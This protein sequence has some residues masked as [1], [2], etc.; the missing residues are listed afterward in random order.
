MP[1]VDEDAETHSLVE[2]SR[3]MT[4]ISNSEVRQELKEACKHRQSPCVADDQENSVAP[5]H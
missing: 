2:E 4:E 1:G 3:T 5:K